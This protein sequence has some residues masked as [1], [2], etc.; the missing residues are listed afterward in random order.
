MYECRYEVSICCV[1]QRERDEKIILH[2]QMSD[3]YPAW[4]REGEF[5]R[6]KQWE[7]RKGNIVVYSWS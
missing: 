5:K 1:L 2:E 4:E 7:V 6:K 3:G